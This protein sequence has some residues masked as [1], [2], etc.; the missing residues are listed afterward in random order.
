MH[1]FSHPSVKV[2]AAATLALLGAAVAA[3]CLA[4]AQGAALVGDACAPSPSSGCGAGLRCASC[5]PLPGTGPTVCSRTTPVD[6]KAHLGTGLPFNR[7]TWLT[8]HNSFAVVGTATRTGTP[9]IAPPNQEDTVTAQLKNGVRG[10]ML[11]AYDFQNDVWLCHSF[12][13]KCY[14]FAA[15]QPA[16][17]VLKE[18]R[19]FL[20]AN[21]SEVITIFVEDY[22]SPG[23]VGRVLGRS[24]LSKYLF[25]VA[26]MPKEGGDWPLLKDMIAQ[27]HRLLVFT[28]NKGKEASDGMAY[29]WDYVLETQYGNDGLVGGWCPKR[30]ESRPMDSPKQSLLLMN[31]FSTNPSQIW[32]CGNNSAPLVAK[33]KACFHASASRWPNFIAVDFY[34][35]SKGGGAPL[36]TDVANGH[37]QCGCDNIAHCKAGSAFGSCAMLSPSPSPSPSPSAS[38]KLPPPPS[39]SPA[40]AAPPALSSS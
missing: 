16:V 4:S 39:P 9:I 34:T 14:N 35:R 20:E 22:A 19:A 7:Y 37:L 31:F 10:L 8:T 33:L 40:A 32:A 1:A 30:A 38:P 5:S 6:P 23:A 12:S 3:S 25:P 18:T 28:S 21:P 36:A 2:M 24:G 17:D 27:N 13:G 11:D 26:K 29:Q 15:Y